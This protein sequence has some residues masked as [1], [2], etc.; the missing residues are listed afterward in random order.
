[1]F[2]FQKKSTGKES[3][4]RKLVE[5]KL[6]VGWFDMKESERKEWEWEERNNH[7]HKMKTIFL[8]LC[9]NVIQLKRKY[10]KSLKVMMCYQIY[11]CSRSI[12]II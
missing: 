7:I 6:I 10:E 3:E 11:F 5:N 12:I 2:G 9:K 4:K 8:F 1:M